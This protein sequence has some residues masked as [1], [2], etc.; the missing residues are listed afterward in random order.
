MK[1]NI[2]IKQI[3]KPFQ[4]NIEVSADK[5]ISIRSVLLA[6]Q[7]IGKSR[8]YNLLESEDVINSLKAIKKLGIN[9][10]KFKKFYEING[11][12]INGYDTNKNITINAGNSGTLARLILGLLVNSKEEIKLIGDESLSKRDFLRITDP[13]QKFGVNI[14]TKKNCLPLKIIGSE[15]LRPIKY[16]EKLGS[17]QCKSAV[18]L[19]AIKT[20]GKT[21]IEA[22]KSRDHTELLFKYLK[23]PIKISK[24]KNYD[25]IEIKGP[26]NFKGFEYN[27]P[28]DISSSSF[29]IVLTL[30]AK[31][32]KIKIR[33]VNVNNSRTGI[34]KI[35]NKMNS[36]ISLRNKKNY[37]GELLADIVVESKNNLRGINCPEYLNSSAIDEFLVIFLVAARA[38]GVS[39]FRNLSELNKKESPRLE[40]AIKFLDMIG[41]KFKREKDTIKIYGNPRLNLKGKYTINNFRKDHRVFMMSCIAALSFGGKWR[42]HDKNSINTSFPNFLKLLRY[43]G[44]KID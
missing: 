16:T 14:I 18:M 44:A 9:F 41:I 15:F 32:S 35:L 20:P 3:I 30:L 27:I 22:K 38:K 6:S 39:T 34:I 25:T 28:G 1:N 2:E 29:F 21:I 10:K 42:I 4:K 8:I 43:L 37:R 26:T 23:I 40:M 12:G 19:A 11:F 36:K 13:L 17:A 33:N 31:N 24:K 7:A 5:S